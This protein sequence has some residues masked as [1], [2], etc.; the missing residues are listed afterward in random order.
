M[1]LYVVLLRLVHIFAGMFWVGAGVFMIGFVLPT[2][3]ALGTDG[4]AF[5]PGLVKYTRYTLAMPVASLLT[6][7]AGVLLYLRIVE[8]VSTAWITTPGGLVLTIGSI[9]GIAAFL[10]GVVVMGPTTKRMEMLAQ[11]AE[12][13]GPPSAEQTAELRKLQV[14]Y[15][16]MGIYTLVLM[17]ISLAGMAIA[18][19]I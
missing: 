10:I 13:H 1:D 2:V 16:R 9:A 11:E 8:R 19:Y 14:R 4:R 18:R 6:T 15:G 17:L 12:K 5:M 3:R 7:L